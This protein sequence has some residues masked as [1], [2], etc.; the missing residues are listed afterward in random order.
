MRKWSD[1]TLLSGSSSSFYLLVS[2]WRHCD[3]RRPASSYQI[4]SLPRYERAMY[5]ILL[6]EEIMFCGLFAYWLRHYAASR[7]VAGS[8]PDEVND[9]F[10]FN[11]PN[12]CGRTRLWGF[13]LHLIEMSTRNIKKSLWRVERCQCVGLTTF[14]PSMSR[15]SRQCEILNTSQPYRPPRPVI[16]LALLFFTFNQ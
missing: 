14:P 1:T 3:I 7:K 16:V 8:R 9:F 13:T 4:S 10:S 2:E 12:P 11:L 6:T 15:L 5:R